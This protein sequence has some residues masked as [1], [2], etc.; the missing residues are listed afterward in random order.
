MRTKDE[1][2]YAFTPVGKL[3]QAQKMR[4]MKIEKAF[5]ELGTDI[6]D[7]VPECADRTS[8]LR[9]LMEAKFTATQ[10]ITH[11]TPVEKPAAK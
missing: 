6:I 4:M 8:A 10:A 11:Y 5:I 9:K 3:D 1:V 7:L 2:K